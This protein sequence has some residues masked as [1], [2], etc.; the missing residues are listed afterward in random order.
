MNEYERR[1]IEL[2]QNHLDLT[3]AAQSVNPNAI[4]EP[5]SYSLRIGSVANPLVAGVTQQGVIVVQADA[6]FILSYINTGVIVPTT[7]AFYDGVVNTPGNI[8][9]QMQDTGTGD[10][11]YS[12]PSPAA[13]AAGAVLTGQFGTSGQTGIP[14]L[15]PFPRVIRPNTNI[16]FEVTQMGVDAVNNPQPVGFFVTLTGSRVGQRS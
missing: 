5:F 16:K 2:T 3:Q 4:V 11:I 12:R 13:I 7:A 1:I 15:L 6:Y 8:S 9:F 10:I 14:M